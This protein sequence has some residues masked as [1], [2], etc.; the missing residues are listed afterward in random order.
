MVPPGDELNQE[1]R[2]PWYDPGDNWSLFA[3]M[4]PEFIAAEQRKLVELGALESADVIEGIWGEAEGEVMERMM[5]RANFS[6]ERIEDIPTEV[7]TKFWDDQNDSASTRRGFVPPAYRKLDL[8]RAELTV[9]EAIRRST[10][11]DAS[12]DELADLGQI[13]LDLHRQSFVADV[14]A[15]RGE[16]AAVGQAI[17][18]GGEVGVGAVEEVDWEARFT[19]AVQERLGTE[20]DQWDRTQDVAQR[21]QLIGGAMS[22]FMQQLGGGIGG[23]AGIGGQ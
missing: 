1:V 2:R 15:A 17:E 10:G 23:G 20:I 21:Q 5:A 18:T 22:N 3:G 11:R 6:A 8:A 12:S 4:S 9:E 19:Q 16:Y 7:W 13:M 14:S